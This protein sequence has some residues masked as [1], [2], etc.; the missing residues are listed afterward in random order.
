MRARARDYLR[1]FEARTDAFEV[2]YASK[3]LP[4]TAAY[5]VMREEGL[6]ASPRAASSGWHSKP[7]SIR[8]RHLHGN[9][10]SEAELRYAFDSGIGT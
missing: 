7:D 9:N 3:S 4:C 10:K 1:A 6:S 2:I 8:P 5:R